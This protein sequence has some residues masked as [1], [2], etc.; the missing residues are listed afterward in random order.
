VQRLQEA[1]ALLIGKANL[2]QFATGLTGT[3]SPYGACFNPF[4]RDYIAGGSSSGS[5]LAV[6]T[7][8][9]SFALGTDTAGS[10]R[11]PAGYTNIVGLKPTRGLVS[12]HGV[13]PACRSLDCVSIFALTCDDARAAFDAARGFD[14]ADIFSRESGEGT[15]A[16]VSHP[17]RLGIPKPGQ[18]QFFGDAAARAA[19]ES[20]CAKLPEIGGEPAEIDFAP[21]ADAARLLYDGPWVAERYAGV[22]AF[23]RDNA[24]SVHPVVRDIIDGAARWSAVDAFQAL[25]RLRELERRC[26]EEWRKMDA[27]FVPTTGTIYRLDEIAAAPVERNTHLGYYTNFVNLLDLCAVAVPGPFRAD[28]LPAGVTLIAPAHRD[29]LLLEAG[30]RLHRAAGVPPGA[31][32]LR[33]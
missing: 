25:Y 4:N 33:S 24:Q 13:V 15:D 27:L 3:R 16:P 20:A 7:G 18:L 17:L 22:G 8:L 5:A 23:V 10:G 12:T 32:P 19:F 30:A 21:F 28:G 29:R 1:G 2:D 26:A 14:A 6:S 9:V 11:V 31:W